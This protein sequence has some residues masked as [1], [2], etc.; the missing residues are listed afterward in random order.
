MLANLLILETYYESPACAQFFEELARRY[1]VRAVD[2]AVLQGDLRESYTRMGA[3]PPR[4][5]F[6]LSEQGRRKARASLT[7]PYFP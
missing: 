3:A 7:F 1:G 6:W 4:R 5:Y 2:E